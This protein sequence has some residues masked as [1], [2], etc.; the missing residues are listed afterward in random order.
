MT[1]IIVNYILVGVT[2]SF[3]SDMT[4]RYIIKNPELEF[5][6]AERVAIILL[7]PLYVLLIIF[8]SYKNKNKN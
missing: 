5:T 4:M 8:G 7:W 3:I 6:N 2:L 1:Q